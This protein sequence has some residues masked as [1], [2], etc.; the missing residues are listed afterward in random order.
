[1]DQH[2]IVAIG[3]AGEMA[4][5]GIQRLSAV[6]ADCT[7]ELYDL[8]TDRLEEL[9]Q[10]LDG[11][12][13]Q[14]GALDLFDAGALRHA[15]ERAS[16]VVLGAGPYMRT[17]P[18][19]MRACIDAG[20]NY[21]DFDDDVESTLDALALDADARAA[22]VALRKGCGA[23]PG[24][25]N[26]VAVDAVTRLDEVHTIDVCW[27]TGDEGPRPYGAAVLE[28]ALHMW[29]GQTQVWR[30]G[31]YAVV[32]PFVETDVFPMTTVGDL[33]LYL[34]A[35][36]EAVTLPRRFPQVRSVRVLGGFHS[37]PM[38]GVVR[39]IAL[40]VQ[41]GRMTVAEAIEWLRVVGAD[42][43]G[44]LKG[45]RHALSGM[46]GQVR[47]GELRLGELGSFLWRGLRKQHD[48]YIVGALARATGVCDGKPQTVTVRTPTGGPDTYLGSSMAAVTGTS[49]AAFVSLALDAGGGPHGVLAPEDWV[50][51]ATFYAA[52][53]KMGTPRHEIVED[54][55]F[56]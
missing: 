39:G 29:S 52:L 24:Y 26:I 10:S 4:R 15:V 55:V 13:A 18:P 49:L 2:R 40:A 56:S 5:V 37:L 19:V 35:H 28:H 30:D 22:G 32:E 21:I 31:R 27:V 16:L 48:P 7:F 3:A 44:S 12:R 9:A 17:A 46:W 42:G 34:T 53:E 6:R 25:S 50:E 8:D 14:V 41:A 20:V 36:P 45:W 23:S 54:P 51:P 11:S 43:N 1:M 38:N 47:R 33:R